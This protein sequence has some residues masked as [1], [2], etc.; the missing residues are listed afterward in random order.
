MTGLNNLG[1]SRVAGRAI[2]TRLPLVFKPWSI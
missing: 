1:V 2:G